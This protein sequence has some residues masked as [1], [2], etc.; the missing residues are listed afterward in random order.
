MT[1]LVLKVW[2]AIIR[3]KTPKKVEVENIPAAHKF[4]RNRRLVVCLKMLQDGQM[5]LRTNNGV[6]GTRVEKT[7]DSTGK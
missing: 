7:G 4:L 1:E 3:S 2:G 5:P 6:A